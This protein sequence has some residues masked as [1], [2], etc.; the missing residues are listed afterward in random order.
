[1]SYESRTYDDQHGDPVVVL[2]ATGTHDVSRLLNLL[3]G[4][5]V[6]V[7]EHLSLSMRIWRQV[8]RHNGGLAALKLLREHGGPD[9]ID[10]PR[11]RAEER[12]LKVHDDELR[13]YIAQE[14]GRDLSRAQNG[15]TR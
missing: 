8:R 11:A 3:A 15:S 4:N 7:S 14:R 5:R 10:T 12:L 2:V 6:P 9:L 1:V 13:K